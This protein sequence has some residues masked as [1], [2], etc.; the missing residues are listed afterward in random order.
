VTVETPSA[1][2][3]QAADPHDAAKDAAEK[4]AQGLSGRQALDRL[5]AGNKRFLADVTSRAHHGT[6]RRDAVAAKQHP[7]AVVVCCSD[8]RVPPELLFDQGLGDL[9]VVRTAGNVI[10][11]LALGSI[12]YACDHLHVP[13]VIVLGHERCGAVT[14]AV[15]GGTPSGHVLSVVEQ[16]QRNIGQDRP[17]AGDVVEQAIQCNARTVAQQITTST[18]ILAGLVTSEHLVVVAARYDLD[19]GEVTLLP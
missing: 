2:P 8:S 11:A 10:D 7:V 5:L 17:A 9:F 16:V 18:P 15:S 6:T 4:P 13:L 1:T 19:S 12:E 3:S 14:A